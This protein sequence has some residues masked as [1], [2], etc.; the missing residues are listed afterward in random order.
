MSALNESGVVVLRG[1]GASLIF[2][3]TG[4]VPA[5][6]HWGADLGH[7]DDDARRML[8]LTAVPAQLNAAPDVPRVFGILPSE[9]TGWL[10]RP[11]IAVSRDGYQLTCR[12]STTQISASPEGDS[13]AFTLSDEENGVRVVA[14]YALSMQGVISAQAAVTSI[15]GSVLSVERLSLSLPLPSRATEILDFS[16]KWIR[17]RSPQRQQLADGIHARETRRGK[18]GSDSPYVMSAGTPGFSHRTG[19][20][21]SMHIAWSGDSTWHVE[22]LPEGAGALTTSLGGAELLRTGEVR[23]HPGETYATSTIMFVWSGN[24]LDGIRSRFHAHLRARPHH[25]TSPRPLTL[26]SWE[27]VYFDHDYE[28]L[29]QLI[30]RAAEVGVERFVLDDGWFHARHDDTAGLGDWWI[31]P[32]TWPQGFGQLV[33]HVRKHNMQFGLWFEPEMVNLDSDTARAHPDWVLAPASG[34]GLPARSQHVLNLANHDAWE[35]ILGF[36]DALIAEHAIDY[37]KWDHNRDLVEASRQTSDGDR[38]GTRDQTLA[39]YALMDELRR[40]HPRLE[41]ESC[42]G[43]GGRIDLGILERTDRVWGSDCNDPVER[44]VIQQWTTLLI[45]P[46]LMGAHIGEPRAHTTKRTTEQSFRMTTALFAH[47]GIESNLTKFAQPEID[48]FRTW[49][50]LYKEMRSLI[51]SGVAV[52]ADLADDAAVLHGVVAHD[53]SHALFELAQ[54]RT[55]SLGQYGRVPIPGLDPDRQYQVR[56][57]FDVGAPMSQSF[58]H[59]AWMLAGESDPLILDGNALTVLGLPLPSL[60]PQQ[61]VIIEFQRVT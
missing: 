11:G 18:T 43:G 13:V 40:R 59:P 38:A 35:Y 55:S 30:D 12:F 48:I 53:G 34:V 37:I 47:S 24:G 27:A 15:A 49:A 41:I 26:N 36:M 10:G 19:E 39:A 33:A 28:T 61:A 22:R 60:D 2:D 16:G 23:L 42:A 46:E 8:A 51:H 25:P 7:L 14:T 52:N 4:A 32:L 45:P 31:D 1:G 20:V 5:V 9:Q 57:R 17:E 54:V 3:A 50:D 29:T 56:V 21:W 44:Q 58:T 6:I